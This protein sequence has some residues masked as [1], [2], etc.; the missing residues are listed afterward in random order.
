MIGERWS[1]RRWTARIMIS[2]GILTF[3]L[4]FIHSP[5][6]FYIIHFLVGAAEAGSFLAVIVYLTH[7]FRSVDRAKAVA[8]FYAAMPLSY[9]I[10]SP[11]AGLLLG[12]SWFGLRGWRWL[13][14]LEGG[15]CSP[16]WCHYCVLSYRLAA[17]SKLAES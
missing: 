9:V 14:I 12:I 16:A 3:L 5:R 10:G 7:W 1:A 4:A 2:W 15:S 17:R 8:A 6:Q 11:L 13:F